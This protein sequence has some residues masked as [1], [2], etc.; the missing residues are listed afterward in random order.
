MCLQKM[1]DDSKSREYYSSSHVAT[2]VQDDEN[3][4]TVNCEK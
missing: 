4:A 3:A 1:G 2:R